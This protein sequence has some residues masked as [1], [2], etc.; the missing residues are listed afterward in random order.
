MQK[1][2]AFNKYST[3]IDDAQHLLSERFVQFRELDTTLQFIFFPNTIQFEDLKLK[4]FDW[5]ELGYLGMELIDFQ[6]SPVWKTKF[7]HMNQKL[8]ESELKSSLKD[9]ASFETKAENI[10]LAE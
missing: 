9:A 2:N 3:I 5:L 6:E 1:K 8:E 7:L 4:Q 10:I